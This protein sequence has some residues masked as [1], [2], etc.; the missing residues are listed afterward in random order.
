MTESPEQVEELARRLRDGDR[1][2]LGELFALVRPR[3]WR[4]VHFRLD[5]RLAGRID[6]DDVLQEAYL[7]A[8]QRLDHLL[9]NPEMP[10]FLWLRLI[11][12]QTLVDVH[13]RHLG[14]QR[15]DAQRERSL[16]AGCQ[17]ATSMSIAAHLLGQLTSPSRAAVRGE[18]HQQLE[19]ALESMHEIDREVLALRHFEELSNSET[20]GVLG[21]SEKA[22]SNRYTRALSRL[23]DILEQIPGYTDG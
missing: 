14:T 6:A 10:V 3:L 16:H 11:A 22:A 13:R 4:T 17:D 8:A 7:N 2:A 15:R 12:N 21:I 5:H 1:Q 9:Q 18:M 19:Q 23:R 20:A